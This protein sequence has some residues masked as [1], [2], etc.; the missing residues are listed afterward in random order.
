MAAL[1]SLVAHF[2]TYPI[3]INFPHILYMTCT[4]WRC[5]VRYVSRNFVVSAV[6][7]FGLH[8][9]LSLFAVMHIMLSL[10]ERLPCSA[11][12]LA[13]IKRTCKYRIS[14]R[15]NANLVTN[16]WLKKSCWDTLSTDIT[17]TLNFY[18]LLCTP[19]CC[20]WARW[21]LWN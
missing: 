21:R 4:N 17:K 8:Y 20:V 5:E 7:S 3:F 14:E 16:T 2:S 13:V 10:E 18:R 11:F 12:H 9:V 6:V 1:M 19:C 15:Q